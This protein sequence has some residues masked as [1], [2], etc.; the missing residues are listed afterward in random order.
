[1]TVILVLAT[2]AAFLIID[3]IYS[4]RRGVQPIIVTK[5]AATRGHEARPVPAFV[6]GFRVPENVRYHQGH[7]WALSESPN[8]VRCGMDDFAGKLAGNIE[9]IQLP[10]RGQWVRQGQKIWS[11]V[12]NGVKVDMVSPIE[13][14]VADVNDAVATDP[15]LAG[16][17]PYGE[18]WVVTVQSPDSK[19]NFRNLIGGALSRVW[20]EESAARLA[21]RVPAMA[22]AFAADGGEIVSDLGSVVPKDKWA[23]VAKEFFLS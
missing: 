11:V 17:D 22:G 16:K 21:A 12:R 1:M 7:T 20:M 4:R 8:L 2:F 14:S 5:P 10:Q 9:A 23:E 13:G 19:I 6:A 18:G 15:T 3:H